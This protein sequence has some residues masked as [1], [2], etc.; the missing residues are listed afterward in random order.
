MKQK[1]LSLTFVLLLLFCLQVSNTNF[2]VWADEIAFSEVDG[3]E[4]GLK[5]EDEVTPIESSYE[6]L[7]G[8]TIRYDVSQDWIQGESVEVTLSYPNSG[9]SYDDFEVQTNYYV[10]G[11]TDVGWYSLNEEI[12]SSGGFS[13]VSQDDDVYYVVKTVADRTEA[14]YQSGNNLSFHSEGEGVF[15]IQEGGADYE[16]GTGSTRH[17]GLWFADWDGDEDIDGLSWGYDADTNSSMQRLMNSGNFSDYVFTATDV[18]SGQDFSEI[19]LQYNDSSTWKRLD[20][21]FVDFDYDGD[22]DVVVLGSESDIPYYFENTGSSTTPMYASADTTVFPTVPVA[23]LNDQRGIVFID[24]DDDGDQDFIIGTNKH[25]YYYENNGTLSSSSFETAQSIFRLVGGSEYIWSNNRMLDAMFTDVDNDGDYDAY[26]YNDNHIYYFENVGS[27]SSFNFLYRSDVGAVISTTSI[28]DSCDLNG[29]GSMDYVGSM[30]VSGGGWAFRHRVNDFEVQKGRVDVHFIINLEKESTITVKAKDDLYQ[31]IAVNKSYN[32]YSDAEYSLSGDV[33][34]GNIFVGGICFLYLRTETSI[35]SNTVTVTRTLYVR[36]SQSVYESLATDSQGHAIYNLDKQIYGLKI[37]IDQIIG[38]STDDIGHYRSQ[39]RGQ[40]V[41]ITEHRVLVEIPGYSVNATVEIPNTWNF[42]RFEGLTSDYSIGSSTNT[43]TLYNTVPQIYDLRSYSGIGFGFNTISQ[44]QYLAISDVSSDYLSDI[45]FEGSWQNDFYVHDTSPVDSV[46]LNSTIVSEGAFSIRMEDTDGFNDYLQC[47][48]PA[49]GSWYLSFDY[50]QESLSAG[51]I[52][53]QFMEPDARYVTLETETNRWHKFFGYFKSLSSSYDWWRFRCYNW[54]GVIFLDNVKIWQVNH[55]TFTSAYQELT[56]KGTLLS[57]DGYD[58]PSVPSETMTVQLRDRTANSLIVEKTDIE[59]DSSGNFEWEVDTSS[60]S[61]LQD[62]REIEVRSWSYDSWFSDYATNELDDAWNFEDTEG[63]VGHVA[64]TFS[65]SNGIGTFIDTGTS[66]S[67]LLRSSLSIDSSKYTHVIGKYKANATYDSMFMAYINGNYKSISSIVDFSSDWEYHLRD[68]TLDSDWN[69]STA[70]SFLPINDITIASDVEVSIDWVKLVEDSWFSKSYFTP[71]SP[72]DWDYVKNL[73]DDHSDWQGSDGWGYQEETADGWSSY[74]SAS[75]SYQD[76]KLIVE[77]PSTSVWA[78]VDITI[79]SI[80]SSTY[81]RMLIRMKANASANIRLVAY[82]SDGGT[83]VLSSGIITS[84]TTWTQYDLTGSTDTITYIRFQKSNTDTK[85]KME[86]DFVQLVERDTPTM[87][88]ADS[89]AYMKSQNNSFT[90]RTEIDSTLQGYYNDLTYFSTDQ[91]IGDHTINATA[92]DDTDRSGIVF[93]PAT[94]ITSSYSVVTDFQVSVTEYSQSDTY[95]HIYLTATKDGAY[96]I[97]E[98]DSDSGNGSFNKD[99]TFISHSKNTT[100]GVLVNL[101]YKFTNDTDIIWF[102]ASYSNS[103]YITLIISAFSL[104]S[105][106]STVQG[107]ITT[108][109][110]STCYIYDTDE[111]GIVTIKSMTTNAGSPTAFSYSGTNLEGQHITNVMCFYQEQTAS[112]TTSYYLAKSISFSISVNS[113]YKTDNHVYLYISSSKSGTYYIYENESSVATGSF[114]DYGTTIQHTRNGSNNIVIELWY[115]FINGSDEL[116]FNTTYSNPISM[117]A[118][119]FIETES[120]Q[121]FEYGVDTLTLNWTVDQTVLMILW[122][123]E[124]YLTH[125]SG[126]TY[127]E[128]ILTPYFQTIGVY[129]FTVETINQFDRRST[130]TMFLTVRDTIPPTF[131]AEYT[132]GTTFEDAR[133]DTTLPFVAGESVDVEIYRNTT[134]IYSDTSTTTFNGTIGTVGEWN[135]TIVITDINSNS[136]TSY[137]VYTIQDTTAP[138]VLAYETTMKAQVGSSISQKW[139][140]SELNPNDYTVTLAG[141]VMD[142]G[143][144]TSS[145]TFSHTFTIIGTYTLSLTVDDDYG[146]TAIVNTII[147]VELPS[148]GEGQIPIYPT[149]T[150]DER[151]APGFEIILGILA[152]ISVIIVIRKKQ[153]R[154]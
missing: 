94:S 20:L 40:G 74:A 28:V 102:N 116:W 105:V 135:I 83:A 32:T 145:V 143:T 114:Y 85:L 8:N 138:E 10:D 119:T 63:F 93:I 151:V 4:G 75:L 73:D 25:A 16:I 42:T 139:S 128:K 113:F 44:K 21:D 76:G 9:I 130:S 22:Y 82:T 15:V 141:I 89:F 90:Y 62:S 31:R 71:I 137:L 3:L 117:L 136:N 50:Y 34:S 67:Y 7:S 18:T 1:I 65:A 108:S 86:F 124:S 79:S 132:N 11:V 12:F 54:Q 142:T 30:G 111:N 24:L 134:L 51:S 6:P 41:D 149:T 33:D 17:S 144:Y 153:K 64:S 59:T 57:W 103:E 69:G 38:T 19:E 88:V 140:I 154:R 133:I 48:F 39:R 121:Y 55:D 49:K 72:T 146:N 58:N 148:E 5:Q 109:Y 46:V 35:S 147:T 122:F 45:G 13:D 99:G 91:T 29:D 100:D 47:D 36:N 2:D 150:E 96:I 98:N 97:Y 125:A 152:L 115:K 68:L 110:A 43:I 78:G 118:A 101:A 56:M 107:S 104:S 23:G 14:W 61:A 26:V 131:I 112:L 123:N 37:Y 27:P 127:L 52:Q 129:N 80:S 53:V 120:N 81:S 77:A 126:S 87:Q 84:P 70:T 66:D 95:V 106:G 92:Y 60:Y